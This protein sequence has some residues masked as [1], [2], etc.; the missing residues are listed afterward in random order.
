MSLLGFQLRS[1]VRRRASEKL[2]SVH[3]AFRSA[4]ALRPG[5]PAVGIAL[6]PGAALAGSAAPVRRR[7]R[8][9]HGGARGQREAALGSKR[10]SDTPSISPWRAETSMFAAASGRRC[11]SKGLFR[12]L[13]VQRQGTL[14][15]QRPGTG[16]REMI[17]SW[18]FSR[19][20]WRRSGG[21]LAGDRAA[22]SWA[23][24]LSPVAR[25]F[26]ARFRGSSSP[27]MKAAKGMPSLSA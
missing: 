23:A 21:D 22:S 4:A 1:G 11:L 18:S 5:R 25:F 2:P 3:F 15:A 27:P 24:H 12:P 20:S 6:I 7:E 26:S 14:L 8:T 9:G 17:A 16:A 10:A 19:I 13:S